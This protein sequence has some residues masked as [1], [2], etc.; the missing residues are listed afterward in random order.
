[1]K[2][3]RQK[4]SEICAVRVAK[5]KK[6]DLFWEHFFLIRRPRNTERVVIFFQ[7][8]DAPTRAIP[9][10]AGCISCS[11]NFNQELEQRFCFEIPHRDLLWGS[12]IERSVQESF[13]ETSM[14]ILYRDVA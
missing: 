12:L 7:H 10:P 3:A 9:H 6:N 11:E 2:V 8:V 14:E 5:S 4:R 1:M 13:H